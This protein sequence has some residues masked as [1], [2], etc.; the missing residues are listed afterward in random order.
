MYSSNF[1]DYIVSVSQLEGMF[2]QLDQRYGKPFIQNPKKT[3]GQH[4]IRNVIKFLAYHKQS[5]CEDIAKEEF[6]KNIQ[7]H[8]KL[9]SI[10]DDVRKFIK[11]NLIFSRLVREDGFKKVKN[12][13]IVSFSL[14][15]VGILYAI[16]LFSN[17]RID[18]DGMTI[19]HSGQTQ[20]EFDELIKSLK[21]D[22]K[23][24]KM[25][26]D[27]FQPPFDF[28]IIRSLAKEYSDVIP[29][30]FGKFDYFENL[31]G[32][33]FEMIFV[34]AFEKL[35]HEPET[36]IPD[37]TIMLSDHARYDYWLK[38]LTTHSP[39]PLI[40]EQFSLL[41]YVNLEEGIVNNLSD[42]DSQEW[43]ESQNEDKEIKQRDN[44]QKTQ[45]YKENIKSA[46]QMWLEILNH[47]KKI[48][49]WYYNFVK[50][51][52]K[53]KRIEHDNL[54]WYKKELSKF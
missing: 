27:S 13:S 39:D 7:T 53:S 49:K 46:K 12:K 4:M 10:T 8:R 24:Y 36:S 32:D 42:R 5:T 22:G 37:Q 11:N 34:N 6:E 25:F 38:E 44:K 48:K 35:F 29:K 17:L 3:N 28:G 18:E 2:K 16:Y 19:I 50:M 43:F 31:I 26:V 21:K 54:W 9:K 30:V 20:E 40:V 45:R 47:D 23:E 33:G 1:I 52:L 51:A 41:F 14:T 15:P